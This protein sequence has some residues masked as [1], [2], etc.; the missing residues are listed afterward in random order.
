MITINI[1]SQLTNLLKKRSNFIQPLA[2]ISILATSFLTINPRSVSA[3]TLI[4]H[5][6]A[7]NPVDEGW[8]KRVVSSGNNVTVNPVIDDLGLG[9]D[10]WSV[11]DN[12]R[13][14]QSGIYYVT[15]VADLDATEVLTQEWTLTGRLRVIDRYTGTF[16]LASIG[17]GMRLNNRIWQLFFTQASNGDPIVRLGTGGGAGRDINLT[18]FGNGYHTYELSYDPETV[19]T[20]LTVNGME[21]FT[22]YTGFSSPGNGVGFSFGS[23]SNYD[24][25]QGNYNLIKFEVGQAVPEPLTILGAGTAVSF[26][27]AFKRKL[28]HKKS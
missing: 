7:N 8:T 21:M 2:T 26:G 16:G 3:V 13:G 23:Y 14:G 17:F 4:L 18:G 25:G 9:I 15:G 28:R 10:A 27:V 5:E 11:D 1:V 20:T 24:D 12:V 19:S 6:G 22:N